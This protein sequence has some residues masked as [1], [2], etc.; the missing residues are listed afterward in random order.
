[1]S[2]S[3]F[4][5]HRIWAAA[6]IVGEHCDAPSHW[7]SMKTLSKWM[8]E[9]GIPGMQGVDTR[10]LTKKIREKGTILGRI[11]YELPVGDFKVTFTDPN[12]RNLVEEVSI[13]V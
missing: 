12:T 7:K 4:E 9:E 2:F 10:E 11:V 5:S 3:W 13:K 6:L 1:M 8:E